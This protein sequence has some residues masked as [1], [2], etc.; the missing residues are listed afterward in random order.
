MPVPTKTIPGDLETE[1]R[2]EMF[3]QLDPGRSKIVRVQ[4]TVERWS[5]GSWGLQAQC[6]TMN[7]FSGKSGVSSLMRGVSRQDLDRAVELVNAKPIDDLRKTFGPHQCTLLMSLC[8]NNADDSLQRAK[9][10]AV[11]KRLLAHPDP[12]VRR[13]IVKRDLVGSTALDYATLLNKPDV[14]H[15]LAE[16]FYDLGEDLNSQDATGNTFLH[17]LARKGDET[18][19]VLQVT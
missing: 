9:V 5:D 11:V 3:L 17:L 15:F 10:L 8:C 18:V 13:D 7:P 6:L 14:A 16:I 19:A 4:A 2:L 12:A 1:G